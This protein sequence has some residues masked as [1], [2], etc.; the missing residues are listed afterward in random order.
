VRTL[1]LS[2]RSGVG[3]AFARPGAH[4]PSV[5]S[6]FGRRQRSGLGTEAV[7]LGRFPT[8]VRSMVAA[9]LLL[10]PILLITLANDA[11]ACSCV[12]PD[13]PVHENLQRSD[14]VF[15]GRVLR[16]TEDHSFEPSWRVHLSV[17]RAWKGV[18][19]QQITIWTAK[20]GAYCGV[21]FEPEQRYVVYATRYV[22]REASRAA[23]G[24]LWVSL[25]SGTRLIDNTS[26]DLS[27]LGPGWIPT[28]PNEPGGSGAWIVWVGSGF[29]LLLGFAAGF[30]IAR[31]SAQPAKPGDAGDEGRGALSKL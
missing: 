17:D 18:H 1:Q 29:L 20:T 16:I 21:D 27:Q 6:A 4:P 31:R 25:C 9:W 2:R 26:E 13:P 3:A 7:S 24:A 30:F 12:P 28:S 14:A 11:H 5:F 22:G 23:R 10:V 19:T 15:T 8:S